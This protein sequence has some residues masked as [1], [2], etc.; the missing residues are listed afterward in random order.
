M[1]CL[2]I[3]GGC[4]WSLWESASWQTNWG[5][6]P[7]SVTY[8]G[9][10]LYNPTLCQDLGWFPWGPE[11]SFCSTGTIMHPHSEHNLPTCVYT[12]TIFS[13]FFCLL[14]QAD[15]LEDNMGSTNMKGFVMSLQKRG[16]IHHT[17]LVEQVRVTCLGISLF[18]N[19]WYFFWPDHFI[20]CLHFSTSAQISMA[21]RHCSSS[22]KC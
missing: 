22:P 4:E 16:K 11:K 21:E 9:R 14:K 5:D 13:K 8:P 15:F 17:I 3:E 2:W 18:K 1:S 19:D 7:G 6:W 10:A 12:H 20:S